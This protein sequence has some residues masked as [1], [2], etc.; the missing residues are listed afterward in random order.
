MIKIIG[1]TLTDNVRVLQLPKT[2]SIPSA[3]INT[4]LMDM[5]EVSILCE[6]N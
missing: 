3:M 6:K 1:Q 2:S 5:S 4:F